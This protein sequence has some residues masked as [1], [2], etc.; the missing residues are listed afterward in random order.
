MKVPSSTIVT[1]RIAI[2]PQTGDDLTG[3]S[4]GTEGSDDAHHCE[5]T[6]QPFCFL[7]VS[8]VVVLHNLFLNGWV[9]VHARFNGVV[10]QPSAVLGGR[11]HFG[12][13]KSHGTCRIS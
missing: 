4:I 10:V 12:L 3:G 6:V 1:A 9:D 13:D 7:V 8:L 2:S 5:A 11:S